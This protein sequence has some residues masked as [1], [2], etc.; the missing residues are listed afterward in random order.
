MESGEVRKSDLERTGRIDAGFLIEYQKYRPLVDDL[1]ARFTVP[2]L[3]DLARKLP[4][5]DDAACVVMP[6][7]SPAKRPQA[8]V[9]WLG[10]LTR[11]PT[12]AS[13]VGLALY[14]AMASQFVMITML[15]EMEVLAQRQLDKVNAIKA[16]LTLVQSKSELLL[17]AV[18]R[19]GEEKLYEVKE[20][21]KDER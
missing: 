17:S 6:K 15:L 7:V 2:E 4:F 21:K 13:T 12:D 1:L 20:T 10:G 9:K 19:G 16:L 5:D 18:T 11:K 14:C 8:M 3:A